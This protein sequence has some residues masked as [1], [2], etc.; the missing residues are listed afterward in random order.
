MFDGIRQAKAIFAQRKAAA[1]MPAR[2]FVA[3]PARRWDA[4]N[5]DLRKHLH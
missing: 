1:V 2:K 4:P 3:P 5:S